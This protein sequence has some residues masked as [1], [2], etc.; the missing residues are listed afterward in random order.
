MSTQVEPP[1]VAISPR[2]FD[3][4]EAGAFIFRSVSPETRRAYA[5]AL[6]DFFDFV[7]WADPAVI[8]PADVLAYRDHLIGRKLK[9]RTVTVRLAVVRSFFS[10][11]V[12]L[13]RVV[14][15]PATTKLVP[16][17]KI[18]SGASGRALSKA[19]VLKL[20]VAPDRRTPE[21]ARDVAMMI[22][23]ARLSLRL[24]EVCGLKASSIK[25]GSKGWVLT[26]VV[27]G[28]REEKWPLP[29]DVKA[30][31][32]EY[33]RLDSSRRELL[34]T[35]G[36]DA[37]L[38][39]PTVNYRT[40]VFNKPVSQ[41]HVEKIVAKWADYA[42]LGRLTPHDLRRT[43]LTEMLKTYPIQEVQMVSKH[44]DVRTLMIYNHDRENLERSPVN[45]FRYEEGS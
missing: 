4:S 43:V 17:P 32:D 19:D 34:G 44:R 26:C 33:L 21:G 24:S 10:Y 45:T 36:P 18:P 42:G 25:A 31:V 12:E 41:R 37:W 2:R 15:N 39:Q 9:P 3:Q 16:P 38:F 35:N 8:T 22:L 7:A 11:L 30:T 13:G 5:A 40:L 20:L 29:E 6:K 27:K 1:Q 28:G 14:R 23:M